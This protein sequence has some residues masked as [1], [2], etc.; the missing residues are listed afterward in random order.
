MDDFRLVG[1]LVGCRF[2]A[3][4]PLVGPGPVG[5]MPAVEAESFLGNLARIYASFGENHGKLRMARST[6]A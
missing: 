3:N 5:G 6:G 1:W 2:E 4:C